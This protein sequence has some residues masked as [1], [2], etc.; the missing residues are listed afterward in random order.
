MSANIALLNVE[1]KMCAKNLPVGS[2][3]RALPV[4]TKSGTP[5][6]YIDALFT[7]TTATCV[8]G[9]V[10]LP[11]ASVWYVNSIG[12]LLILRSYTS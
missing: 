1:R 12:F 9:L 8:T 11:T 4:S 2:F 6:S 5:V 3:L 7:A 10:T